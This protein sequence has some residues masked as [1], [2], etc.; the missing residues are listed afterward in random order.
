MLSDQEIVR[1]LRAIRLSPMPE[2]FARRLPTINTVSQ[3]S[4][5]SRWWLYEI[6]KT[7]GGIGPKSRDRLSQALHVI[8]D[9]GKERGF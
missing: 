8:G 7:G 3:L 2:R 9:D 6:A 5:L 4:G 1:R